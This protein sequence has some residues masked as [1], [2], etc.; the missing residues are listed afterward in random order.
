VLKIIDCQ[1]DFEW[2]DAPWGL[3]SKNLLRIV[4]TQFDHAFTEG[5][6]HFNHDPGA[7][8]RSALTTFPTREALFPP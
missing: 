5:L 7:A 6:A 3:K 4:L 8:E 2:T 1:S